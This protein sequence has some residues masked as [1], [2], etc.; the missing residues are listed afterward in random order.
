[1]AAPPNPLPVFSM[2]C[3]P[4]SPAR[5][6]APILVPMSPLDDTGVRLP[7]ITQ[8][9]QTAL[10]AAAFARTCVQ[11]TRLDAGD[12]LASKAA[13]LAAA[14]REIVPAEDP[15]QDVDP[16]GRRRVLIAGKGHRTVATAGKS[17]SCSCSCW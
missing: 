6:S 16:V 13:R 5:R 11:H 14:A 12:V 8:L 17:C 1:M 7:T 2:S 4:L 9:A 10:Q 3:A 15:L